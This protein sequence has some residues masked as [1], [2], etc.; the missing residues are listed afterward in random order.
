[1]PRYF[2]VRDG[3]QPEI[4]ANTNSTDSID[5][6]AVEL[7]GENR[8]AF[9]GEPH[10]LANSDNRFEKYSAAGLEDVSLSLIHI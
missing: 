9:N 10:E 4:I 7:T 3:A 1:M 6:Y 5:N 8:R 2:L